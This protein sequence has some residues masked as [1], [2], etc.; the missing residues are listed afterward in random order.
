VSVQPASLSRAELWRRVKDIWFPLVLFGLIAYLD[1]LTHRSWAFIL[2]GGGLAL[3]AILFRGEIAK[4]VGLGQLLA[5]VPAWLRPVLAAVPAV[6]WFVIRGQG[7]SGAG[8]SVTVTTLALVLGIGVLGPSLDRALGGFYR[9]R[10]R[11]LPRRLRMLLAAVLP[12]VVGFGV[13]H[14]SLK[15]IPVLFGGT[16]SSPAGA[17]DRPGMY[18]VGTLLSGVLAFLL[19]REGRRAA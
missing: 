17:A 1:F 2:V 19:M 6:L 14:G 10:D 3:G 15:A 18:V 7:T 9:G 5:L 16:T 13:I 12:I 4:R 8:L 11:M